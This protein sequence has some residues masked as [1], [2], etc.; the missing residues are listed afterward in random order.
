[1]MKESWTALYVGVF[2]SGMTKKAG[3]I[4]LMVMQIVGE[5]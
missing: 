4:Y 3:F 5:R 1:M 2:F